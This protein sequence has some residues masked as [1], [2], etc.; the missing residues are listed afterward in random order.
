[1][2]VLPILLAACATGFATI[3]AISAP[4][5][6]SFES[7][8]FEGWSLAISRGGPA[9]QPHNNPAGTTSITASWLQT[10]G[11]NAVYSPFDGNKFATLGTLAGGN[12]TGHRTY[13]ISFSQ[14]FSLNQG[15]I[16]SGW[17]A[18]F[19][20]DYEAQD[21][22]WIR[23]LDRDG[24]RRA[25]P[26]RENSGSRSERDFNSTPYQSATPWTQWSWQVPESGN[27]TLSMGMT[28]SGDNNY[29]S[30]GFFDNIFI[31]PTSTLVPEPSAVTL[32]AVG[33]VLVVVLRRRRNCRR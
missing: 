6:G 2:K 28:T 22:A 13:N 8:G 31:I 17:A 24:V 33:T 21:S 27:Y 30:Y 4:V 16:V 32:V 15:D 9:Y 25:T 5:N 19:N 23:V 14:Q 18:F 7:G 20:G 10:V 12:F 11:G 26:W 1:M 29:A 3:P